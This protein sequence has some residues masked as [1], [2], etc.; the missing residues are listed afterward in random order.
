MLCLCSQLSQPRGKGSAFSADN[1]P[2]EAV[3]LT[4]QRVVVGNLRAI[5]QTES[6]I[7]PAIMEHGL[8]NA[9]AA[10]VYRPATEHSR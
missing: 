1:G 4:K 6:P 2:V 5:S 10:D 9:S 7:F 3:L 8:V